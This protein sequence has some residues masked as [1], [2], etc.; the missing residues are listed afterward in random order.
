MTRPSDDD[1]L[2]AASKILGT[3]T[4]TIALDTLAE[5]L[6]LTNEND[7]ITLR[8]TLPL[9]G[10]NPS[11][12]AFFRGFRAPTLVIQDHRAVPANSITDLIPPIPDLVTADIAEALDGFVGTITSIDAVRLTLPPGVRLPRGTIERRTARAM[13]HLGFDRLRLRTDG[14]P[15]IVYVRGT[16]TV[17]RRRPIYVFREFDGT[18][19]VTHSPTDRERSRRYR[20][21][22]E[23]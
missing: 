6:G 10:F 2:L 22:T 7:R 12:L 15:S 16:T 23:P 17:D 3:T 11:G 19:T 4:G 1:L 9:L 14:K 20:P 21:R 18:V 5:E 8:R 13:R